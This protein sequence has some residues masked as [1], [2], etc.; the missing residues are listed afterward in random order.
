[1][2]YLSEEKR[3]LHYPEAKL[4]TMWE[5]LA[6]AGK[7]TIFYRADCSTC[8]SRWWVSQPIKYCLYCKTKTV[9]YNIQD[10]FF[11]RTGESLPGELIKPRQKTKPLTAD[12]FKRRRKKLWPSQAAAA[13]ALGVT[14]HAVNHWESGRRPVPESA[15][16]LLECIEAK[17]N[18]TTSEQERGQEQQ[19]T[20]ASFN[21]AGTHLQA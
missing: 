15:V 3:R 2:P 4:L 13:L 16:K 12:K 20:V 17:A 1:M 19:A 7:G 21:P 18:S 5:R 9:T 6:E 8:D 14:R 10:P 11:A